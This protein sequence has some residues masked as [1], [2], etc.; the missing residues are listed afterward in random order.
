[1]NPLNMNQPNMN[2]PNM[3]GLN[4]NGP[5]MNLPNINRPNMN[6]MEVPDPRTLATEAFVAYLRDRQWSQEWRHQISQVMQD[7]AVDYRVRAI[8]GNPRVAPG[9]GADAD[10]DSDSETDMSGLWH[11]FF[12]KGLKKFI[13][14]YPTIDDRDALESAVDQLTR[15]EVEITA[16]LKRGKVVFHSEVFHRYMNHADGQSPA[17]VLG[18]GFE[19]FAKPKFVEL[20][21]ANMRPLSHEIVGCDVEGGPE[22][23]TTVRITNASHNIEWLIHGPATLQLVP[24]G[25]MPP[26][27]PVAPI[28]AVPDGDNAVAGAVAGINSAVVGPAENPRKKRKIEVMSE[29]EA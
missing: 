27:A 26:A 21:A 16:E 17:Q 3:Y 12:V 4:M 20:E 18:Y 29:E 25:A 19:M 7:L 23:V 2:L 22:G 1:M 10:S 15:E 24:A 14:S 8:E 11:Q 9:A 5:N 13:R 6:H 28:A